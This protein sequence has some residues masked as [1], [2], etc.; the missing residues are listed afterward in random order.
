MSDLPPVGE[1]LAYKN[2][3][4][5]AERVGWPAGAVEA[6]EA[7]DAAHDGWYTTWVDGYIVTI[8][9]RSELKPTGYYAQSR[10]FKEAAPVYGATPQELAE[11]IET[12]AVP[13]DS[14]WAHRYRP[15]NVPPRD[16]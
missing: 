9:G 5:I 10:V 3:R 13:E 16:D 6:C 14:W 7:I 8:D 4:V 2:R 1:E 12:W 11:A 15:L